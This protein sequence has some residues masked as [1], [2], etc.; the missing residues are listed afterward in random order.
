M[1]TEPDGGGYMAVL[2]PCM[3]RQPRQPRGDD[4]CGE[5]PH[6]HSPPVPRSDKEDDGQRDEHPLRDDD[7]AEVRS[8]DQVADE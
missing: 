4:R 6:L 2:H 3:P 7:P 1:Q 8:R 5:H